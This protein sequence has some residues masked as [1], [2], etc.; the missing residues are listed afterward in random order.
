MTAVGAAGALGSGTT[1]NATEAVRWYQRAADAGDANGMANLGLAYLDGTGIA[2]DRERALHWFRVAAEFGDVRSMVMLGDLLS[3]G[4]RSDALGF[5]QA[6]RWYARA[7][8]EGH[9]GAMTSLGAL[10]AD[11]K[12]TD[13]KPAEA[14]RLFIAA[15]KQGVPEAMLNLAGMYRDGRGVAK[16]DSEAYFWARNGAM[17]MTGE[18]SSA[19]ERFARNLG[20]KL[21]SDART[22]M[23]ARSDAWL[24]RARTDEPDAVATGDEGK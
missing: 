24:A 21:D 8:E 3:R 15:A 7:S 18:R 13:A 11:G 14:V 22:A 20:R 23:D 4:D 17:A 1:V 12:G 19:A 6:I 2:Q 10:F 16:S 9:A 5:S